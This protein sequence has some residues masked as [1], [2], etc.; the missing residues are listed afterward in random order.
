MGWRGYNWVPPVYEAL[1]LAP[2]GHWIPSIPCHSASWYLLLSHFIFQL[3]WRSILSWRLV[4]GGCCCFWLFFLSQQ[5]S[6]FMFCRRIFC[7][8]AMLLLLYIFYF[9]KEFIYL[10]MIEREERERGRDTGRGRSRLSI[11]G[12]Q[13]HALGQRQA[14]NRWATQGSQNLH[15]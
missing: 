11:P 8:A 1:C 9:F 5:I 4:G 7:P 13:D 15:F 10:F 14:L 2:S 6:L 12:F 3:G